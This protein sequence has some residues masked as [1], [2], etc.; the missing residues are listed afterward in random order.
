MVSFFYSLK[1]KIQNYFIIY[2]EKC[3]IIHL[4]GEMF[5]EAVILGLIISFF[6]RGR[7]TNL[8]ELNIRGWY[9]IFISVILTLSPIFLANFDKFEKILPIVMFLALLIMLVVVGLNYDKKGFLIILI[10]GLFNI[11]VMLFFSFKMPVAMDS[12]KGT[13]LE[14]LIDDINAGRI[15]NYTLIKGPGLLK[16]FSK[17]IIIPNYPFAKVISIGDIIISIGIIRFIVGESRR[18]NFLKKSKMINYT[19]TPNKR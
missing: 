6:I 16:Y 14:Y 1:I 7:I 2:V 9:L 5:V 13:A 3:G 12:L 11:I 4:G 18:T 15:I 10:G 17:F 8:V 19:F